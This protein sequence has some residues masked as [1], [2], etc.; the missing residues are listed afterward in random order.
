MGVMDAPSPDRPHREPHELPEHADYESTPL[1]RP[2]YISA[3]VHLYRGELFRANAW[4][5]R[6]DQ[7][8]NWAVLTS[9]GVLTYSFGDG[10]HSPWSII[11]GLAI[12]TLFLYIEARRFRFADVWRS[13]V[14]MIEEN[15]YGPILRRDPVSPEAQWGTLVAVDLFRPSFKMSVFAALRTRLLRNYLPIYAVLSVAFVV[16][17]GTQPTTAQSWLEIRER[18]GGDGIVPWW[19]PLAVFGAFG[20]GCLVLIVFGRRSSSY[21][22]DDWTYELTDDTRKRLAIDL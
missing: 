13:R 19:I 2:E 4:R 22:L 20:L 7:T 17:V 3:I 15:F 21:D 11:A 8:T 16:K 5:L 6:L 9:A 14:R 18:M 12:V 10:H 1:T